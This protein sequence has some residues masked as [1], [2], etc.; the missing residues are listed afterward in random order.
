[1]IGHISQRVIQ[2]RGNVQPGP[3]HRPSS[4]AVRQRF[5]PAKYDQK[6]RSFHKAGA[7]APAGISHDARMQ[8]ELPPLRRHAHDI[9]P[10]HDDVIQ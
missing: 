3:T 7:E 9:P 8:G 2:F 1:M 5:E 6:I 4:A 10:S